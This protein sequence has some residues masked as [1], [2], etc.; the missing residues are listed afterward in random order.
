MKKVFAFVLIVCMLCVGISTAVAIEGDNDYCSVCNKTTIWNECCTGIIASRSAYSY[1]ILSD[2]TVC[3]TYNANV[4]NGIRCRT[5][6]N[7]KV[8]SSTHI[9]VIHEY[10]PTVKFC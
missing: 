7:Q 2:G 4:R 5:C 8:Y 9:H 10:C 6:G 1:H 3:N